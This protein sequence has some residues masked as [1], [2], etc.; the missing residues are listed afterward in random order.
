MGCVRKSDFQRTKAL[1]SLKRGK[2]GQK[3]LLRTIGNPIRAFDWCQNQR[4]WMT[5]N[6]N[7][8]LC[9]MRHGFVTY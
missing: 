5:L 6:D 2:I 7:Y 1:I 4:P 3:L 8:V 9:F